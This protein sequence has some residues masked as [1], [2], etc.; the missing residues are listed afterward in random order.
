MVEQSIKE[1]NGSYCRDIV[2]DLQGQ[3]LNFSGLS[4]GDQEFKRI[5]MSCFF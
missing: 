2:M 5:N 4:G 1:G 3:K